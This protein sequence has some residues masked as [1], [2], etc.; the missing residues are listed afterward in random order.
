MTEEKKRS[1]GFDTLSLHAGYEP[2]EATGSRAVPIYQ[3]TSYVFDDADHAARL[4]A[5]EEAGNIYT[6]IGN[7]TH[8][9]FEQRIAALEGGEAALATSSGMSAINLTILTLLE[10]GDEI[11]SSRCVYGGTYNLF[12]V[13]LPKYGIETKFVDPD[14][15]E[16]WEEAITEDTK[17]FY[18]ESPGNPLL[19]IV[20]IEAVAEI[21]HKHDIMVVFDNTFN[22]P[23]LCQPLSLGADIVVHSATKYIGGHGSSIGGIIVG[24]EDFIFKARTEGYRDTGPALSPMNSWLFIQGLE[25]LSLRMEKHSENAQ[26]VAEWLEEH[27]K[28]EW[29]RYPGL[30]S[31]PQH[32]LAKKQQ[33]NFGGMLCFEIK[34][35]FEAGKKLINSVDLC[36][37]LANVGDTRTLIIHPASTTH[38][39][40]TTEEQETAGITEGLIR[41]S[42][43]IENIEDIIADLEQAFSC[44]D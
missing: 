29:V 4:F 7:P 1:L 40:L 12:A 19:N 35:G 15:L 21:A 38:E 30:E 23:Y 36:S 18:L 17:V 11:V 9:V 8:S 41:L 33:K 14:D 37:L 43:G 31:H 25:T 24:S 26:Q 44:V 34:G 27:D 39:Q 6:R 3:T 5:L 10:A 22:T 13:T 42:V 32:E 16:A 20:D 2:D 28:V